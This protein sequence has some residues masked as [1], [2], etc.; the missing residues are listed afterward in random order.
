MDSSAP[1]LY[2]RLDGVSDMN[3]IGGY[4]WGVGWW[5]WMMEVGVVDMKRGASY[6]IF[7]EIGVGTNKGAGLDMGGII[8]FTNFGCNTSFH[9]LLFFAPSYYFHWN[10]WPLVDSLHASHNKENE[11]SLL[12][13]CLTMHGILQN[14]LYAKNVLDVLDHLE[15]FCQGGYSEVE[16]ATAR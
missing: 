1:L 11:Y 16:K 4:G 14:F 6:D 10:P 2:I 9:L 8:P 12:S 5:I 7:F 15:M 3:G 13:I